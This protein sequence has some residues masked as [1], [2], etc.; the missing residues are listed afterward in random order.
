MLYQVL[1]ST[2]PRQWVKNLFVLAALV[3]SRHLFEWHYALKAAAAALCFCGLSGGIY[4]VNDLFDR[5]QDARHPSK[6]LR[7]VASGALSTRAA[8]AAAA[9]LLPL[10]LAASFYLGGAFGAI[11]VAYTAINLAYSYRLKRLVLVDILIVASGFLIRA[12]AGAVVIEVV[13][14]TWFILCSFTLA[15]FLAAVKRR[16]ELVKLEDAA[17]EHRPALEEYGVPYLDQ[18][19]SVLTSATLVCYCLYAMGVGE[20]GARGMEWTIPFVL[21]GMLRYLYLVYRRESGDSP[22]AIVWQDR[23]LQVALILWL[24]ASL[25]GLH[26]RG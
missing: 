21:Y 13:I 23:P 18:V 3:F 5:E 11:A 26:L 20:G 16:Q 9:L 22:T 4:L 1:L 25:A 17:A 12:V 6:R 2:R 24:A 19:I 8:G 7:P 14:S 10:S 15:L